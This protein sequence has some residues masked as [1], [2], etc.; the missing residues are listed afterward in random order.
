[1]F[2]LLLEQQQEI[3][4]PD[5]YNPDIGSSQ[6]QS[7]PLR[8]F[9]HQSNDIVGLENSYETGRFELNQTQP[10]HENDQLQTFDF[11]RKG[12]IPFYDDTQPLNDDNAANF[13]Q[14][15]SGSVERE[16]Q[17]EG[18]SAYTD[19]AEYQPGNIYVSP[20]NNNNNMQYSQQQYNEESSG[21][22][23]MADEYG[24]QDYTQNNNPDNYHDTE[25][26]VL[27]PYQP[28]QQDQQSYLE[29]TYD[30]QQPKR[31]STIQRQNPSKQS[32]KKK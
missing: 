11:K 19:Q 17:F 23:P 2:R 21:F 20:E 15:N 26:A 9:S 16:Y 27:Q 13:N 7:L 32:L 12:S 3:K 5:I 31:T 4:S 8:K 18:D 25:P 28:Q 24:Y 10:S 22:G 30:D 1:M 6:L 29:S 14:S